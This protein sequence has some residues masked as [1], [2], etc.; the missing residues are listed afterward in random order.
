MLHPVFGLLF[1]GVSLALLAASVKRIPEGQVYTLRRI[2]GQTRTLGAGMHFKWPLIERVS[3]RI[4]LF[5]NVVPIDLPLAHGQSLRGTVYVQVID[6]AR[7]DPLID[8]IDVVLRERLAA[9]VSDAGPDPARTDPGRLKV[10][11][12]REFADRGL[13]IT[14]VQLGWG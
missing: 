2:G 5:G 8:T 14:R 13:L 10:A 12:N 7:A 11:L 6:P 9:L 3:H 4:R 1:M